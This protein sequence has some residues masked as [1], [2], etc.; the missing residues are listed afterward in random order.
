LA[1]SWQRVVNFS[2]YFQRLAR[3]GLVSFLGTGI[4]YH[5]GVA[6][7]PQMEQNLEAGSFSGPEVSRRQQL[8]I[9]F[10]GTN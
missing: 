8:G 6:R 1:E 7:I 9:P 2:F 5:T 10:S 4:A 3:A